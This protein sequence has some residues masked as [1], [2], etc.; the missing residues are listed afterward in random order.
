MPCIAAPYTLTRAAAESAATAC[1]LTVPGIDALERVRRSMNCDLKGLCEHINLISKFT[2]P[3]AQAE[4]AQ[5]QERIDAIGRTGQQHGFRFKKQD[6]YRPAYLGAKPPSA[7]E[8]M[9]QSASKTPGLGAT[10]QK[11]LSAVAHANLNGLSRFLIADGRLESDQPGQALV[12]L[13][14][15]DVDLAQQLLA[16]PMCAS[17]LVEHLGWFAG[18]D[19]DEIR[20][21]VIRMLHTWGR[22]A[23]IPYAGP[24]LS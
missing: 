21:L 9:D 24:D 4:V 22:I 16:G 1:Y 23:R 3:G 2:V 11:L 13:N 15:S 10:Y 5:N 17:T 6:G 14:V 7:M 18:W 12:Q 19:T 8:L 20:P